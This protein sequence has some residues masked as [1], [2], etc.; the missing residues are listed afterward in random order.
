MAQTKVFVLTRQGLQHLVDSFLQ[1]A[2]RLEIW[3]S[4]ERVKINSPCKVKPG[5]V[6]HTDN[7]NTWEAGAGGSQ[8]QD[9]SVLCG[10]TLSWKQDKPM[11]N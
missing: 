7:L 6:A 9:Q 1:K 5:V 3:R 4:P 8:V 10:D 2:R 11:K